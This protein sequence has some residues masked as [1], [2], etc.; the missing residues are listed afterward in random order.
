MD[1]LL[2]IAILLL[3]TGISWW[4]CY[5]V[6]SSWDE[7]KIA[8]GFTYL[9]CWCGAVQSA[10]GFSMLLVML[11]ILV[12]S[13]TGKLPPEAINAIGGLWYL[14]IVVPAIG[15]GIIITLH[16]WQVA[17]RDRS[18][19]NLASAAYNTFATAHNLYSAI[20]DVPKAW[21]GVGEFFGDAFKGSDSDGKGK[22]A[23]LVILLVVLA[24][25]GG[26]LITIGLIGRYRRFA[27][28]E[29]HQEV[30]RVR[31]AGRA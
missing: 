1:L 10:V 19:G 30:S 31:Q 12:V 22:L 5:A 27:L 29:L 20:E 21:S 13:M 7:A 24:L 2:L 17:I 16:S 23:L 25:V 14:A 26:V 15:T 8:G 18:A 9:L 6:G 3:N 4:N 28:E 11:E